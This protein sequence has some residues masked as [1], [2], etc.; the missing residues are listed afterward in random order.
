MVVV[1]DP[2]HGGVNP[3]AVHGGVR[4]KDINRLL[5]QEVK[6][7]L[8]DSF[9]VVLTRIGDETVSLAERVRV[10]STHK[11]SF[12][13]SLHSNAGGGHGFESF[14]HPTA[15]ELSRK[16]QSIIHEAIMEALKGY[17]IRDR[18]KKEANFYVLRETKMPALLVESLFLDNERERQ[19]LLQASFRTVLAGAIIRGVK[20][21]LK[22]ET[23]P[24][25]VQREPRL[26]HTVQVGAFLNRS[27]AEIYLARAR[28]KGFKDAFIVTRS[29]PYP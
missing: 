3:G 21:A 27:G 8:K 11:A 2:G 18:G 15:S 23:P 14:V 17:N 29:V 25:E 19:L 6:A 22:G 9:K 5:A 24:Q 4:E 1:I 26:M 10:A 16:Y 7:G 28:E 13:L 20:Q 12:F